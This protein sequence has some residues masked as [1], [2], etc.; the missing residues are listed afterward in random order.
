[1]QCGLVRANFSLAIVA[2]VSLNVVDVYRMDDQAYFAWTSAA[3][4]EGTCS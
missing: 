2:S 1:L 3:T 4:A